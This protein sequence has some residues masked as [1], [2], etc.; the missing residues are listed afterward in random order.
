VGFWGLVDD[1]EV[2][3]EKGGMKYMSFT[4]KWRGWYD[5]EGLRLRCGQ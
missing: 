4:D 3:A 5:C 1:G 2:G